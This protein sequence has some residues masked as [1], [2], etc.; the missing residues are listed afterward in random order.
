MQELLTPQ[1]MSRADRLAVETGIK[2]H[3][4]MEAAGQA[5]ADAVAERYPEGRILILCG[6]GNNGGDGFAAGRLLV[7]AGRDVRLALFGDRSKLKGDAAMYSDLWTQPVEDATPDV[8]SGAAVIVDALLGAG[9]DR[10]V[11]GDLAELINA[12]NAQVAPVLAV[13][14]PSGID[15]ASGA[16]RGTAV[17]AEASVTFFRLK[18]GHL[19]YPGR[20]HCG[21]VLLRQIGIPETVLD[22]IAPRTVQNA[23]QL[24]HVPRPDPEGH[25]FTRGHAVV[26]SGGPLQS[27]ASRMSATAAL[28]AGAGLVTLIG[29][30]A[31]LMVHAQHVTAVMLKV[32]DGAAGLSL[33]LRDDR[34]NAFA[35]GPAAGVGE[36]TRMNVLAALEA[37]P[38]LVLDADAITSFA[39][40]P[41]VLY[42]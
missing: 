27:G 9:L 26:M 12:V 32:V 24:W 15:G 33:L 16:V 30:H 40:A 13:D 8:L 17:K 22:Q 25:K 4:L 34:I 14:V 29:P 42:D 28:R 20:G 38:A 37:G 18:P 36:P 2:S 31:A 35:I 10:D 3:V 5:V 6:P 41:Q 21:E 11:T 1:Q 19:L 7:K 23:P 39:D